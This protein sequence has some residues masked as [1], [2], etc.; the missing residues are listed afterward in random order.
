V[1][2]SYGHFFQK[3]KRPEAGIMLAK[4][5]VNTIQQVRGHVSDSQ[6]DSQK[7]FLKDREYMYRDL[8]E[9]MV[10]AG[11]LGE[12]QRVLAML[13]EEEHFSFVR[14]DVDTGS[15]PE[16][17]VD[18][19]PGEQKFVDGMKERSAAVAAAGK[20][21][22]ELK[23]L[24]RQRDLSAEELAEMDSLYDAIDK[25]QEEFFAFIETMKTDMATEEREDDVARMRLDN[26]TDW[27]ARLARVGNGTVLIHLLPLEDKL[28]TLLTMPEA[29]LSKQSSIKKADLFRKIADFR[30]LLVNP[31]ADPRPLG[32]ELY[33][34]LLE[35]I[36]A[37]LQAAG[38]KTL[39][40]WL[41]GALR[42][43]PIAALHDG[44]GYLAE[45]FGLAVTT[46]ASDREPSTKRSKWSIA[47]FGATKGGQGFSA[48]P[49]VQAELQGLVSREGGV[50]K[51]TAKLDEAFTADA[52]RKAS[53]RGRN[54]VLHV[55]THFKFSPGIE[56]ES[57]LLLGDGN[58]LTLQDLGGPRYKFRDVD[59]LTLS[60]CETALGGDKATGREV[61]GLGVLAQRQG[62]R[63]VMAT[64]WQVADGSTAA[65]MRLFY[66]L[67]TTENLTKAEAL[68]RAQQA[69]ISGNA[70]FS[71]DPV[72]AKT[73]RGFT[74]SDATKTDATDFKPFTAPTAAPFAHP[75]YWAPFILMGDWL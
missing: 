37:D 43:L 27:Q 30:S 67:R 1:L 65:F 49:A 53:S 48:L 38:A 74:R 70:S 68:R 23:E 57:Y 39:L 25:A 10:E 40:F 52:F 14:R 75:Y 36:E 54:P 47:G 51:G 71:G 50:L 3:Q 69:F 13:K 62:A 63:A 22:T 60:A 44:K 34:L 4:M 24:E 58:K 56:A 29:L 45:R 15:A 11:R 46:D 61:E 59:L 26:A 31:N 21:L 28:V 42:Y 18:Y 16:K 32:K 17:R 5:A 7:L 2:Y 66:K 9:W 72:V 33:D 12:A 8:A 19:I 64:L 41:D 20:R 73:V 55:A 35:P 6:D